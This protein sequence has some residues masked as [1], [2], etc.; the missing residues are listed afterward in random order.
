MERKNKLMLIAAIG[1][2]VVLNALGDVLDWKTGQQIAG[3]LTE[4]KTALR[5]TA[6]S[7]TR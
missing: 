4:N 5:S 6:A 7:E 1:A 3:P 2:V